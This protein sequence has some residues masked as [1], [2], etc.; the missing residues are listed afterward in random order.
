[1]EWLWFDPDRDEPTRW[2][3]IDPRTGRPDGRAAADLARSHC[4]GESALDAV[5]MVADAIATEFAM[6]GFTDEEVTALLSQRSMPVAFQ[7]GPVDAA[8]LLGSVGDLWTLVENCYQRAL[9]RLPDRVER[10]WLQDFALAALRARG[11]RPIA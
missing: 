6:K 11:G 2:W 5:S 7:G 10:R 8:D 3:T 1:M 9:G 4:L